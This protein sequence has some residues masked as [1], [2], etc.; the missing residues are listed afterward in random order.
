MKRQRSLSLVL[1]PIIITAKHLIL[2]YWIYEELTQFF[3]YVPPSI[4]GFITGVIFQLFE[5]VL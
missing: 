5:V 2:S 4:L 1:S 3:P